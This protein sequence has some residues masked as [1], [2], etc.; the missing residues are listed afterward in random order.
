MV[1]DVEKT[2]VIDMVKEPLDVHGQER[3]DEVFLSGSL[4]IVG[5]G[6]SRV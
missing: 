3:R 6:E 4:D 2:S 5:E 1:E